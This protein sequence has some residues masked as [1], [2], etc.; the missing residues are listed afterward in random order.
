[1]RPQVHDSERPAA[2]PKLEPGPSLIDQRKASP[3]GVGGIGGTGGR[4]RKQGSD[5]TG[6]DP[7]PGKNSA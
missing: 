4:R 1:M 5:T 6:E 7:A 2:I 3:Y